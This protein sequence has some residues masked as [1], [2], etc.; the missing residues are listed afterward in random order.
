MQDAAL[1]RGTRGFGMPCPLL[2]LL[3]FAVILL[4]PVH[5][6]QCSLGSPSP[7]LQFADVGAEQRIP[8]HHRVPGSMDHLYALVHGY[9]EVVQQNPFPTG[10]EADFSQPW[11]PGAVANG[12]RN[13]REQAVA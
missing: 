13:K 3:A 5:S 11:E 8:A 2:L 1:S 9:L 6:Q 10:K 7:I 4:D 12:A